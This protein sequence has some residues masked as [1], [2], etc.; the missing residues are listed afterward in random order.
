MYVVT[1]LDYLAGFG[2]TTKLALT[3]MPLKFLSLNLCEHPQLYSFGVFLFI[4][5]LH[6]VRFFECDEFLLIFLSLHVRLLTLISLEGLEILRY[7]Y[8][9]IINIVIPAGLTKS[10]SKILTITLFLSAQYQ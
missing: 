3:K 5:I 1:V 4:S 2:W 9:A 6:K 8:Q 7:S 10:D